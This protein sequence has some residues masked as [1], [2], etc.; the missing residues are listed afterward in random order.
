MG[1]K[2]FQLLM[3]FWN[4]GLVDTFTVI[5]IC[6]NCGAQYM[7]VVLSSAAV[8]TTGLPSLLEPILGLRTSYQ[9]VHQVGITTF[10]IRVLIAALASLFA[11]STGAIPTDPTT[12][13]GSSCCS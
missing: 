13:A 3:I 4:L 12:N 7:G 9:F 2:E 8:N 11:A 10:E 5:Q 1:Y 6:V